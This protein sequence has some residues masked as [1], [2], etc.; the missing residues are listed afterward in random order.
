M[1]PF[2]H[3]P[4]Q[5][6]S[7]P[8]IIHS[9]AIQGEKMEALLDVVALVIAY[10]LGSI[11]SAI[12]ISKYLKLGDPRTHGS[13]NPG[14]TNILR[15]AGTKA[16]LATLVGDALKGLA[17]ILIARAFNIHGFELGLV[18]LAALLGHI[19]PV[20]F[21]FKGGKGIAVG[22]GILFGLNPMLGILS[23]FTWIA[24]AAIWRYSSLA[25]I[26]TS[27]LTPLYAIIVAHP[28]Y[29]IPLVITAVI[30]VYKHKDNI[31]RLRKGTEGKIN[32]K[33]KDAIKAV[34]E[35]TT[36]VKMPHVDGSSEKQDK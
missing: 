25:A 19:Y 1:S 5:F 23:M 24:V 11:N 4:L 16:A 14:T 34:E 15:T 13:K 8:A 29:F 26:V 35:L 6:H 7:Q 30:L 31:N 3:G 36:A 10:L 21:H 32:F 18:G 22:L 20:F 9:S 33:K 2:G 28:Q 12:L 17:A 27:V